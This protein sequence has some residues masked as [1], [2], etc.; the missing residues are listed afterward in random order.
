MHRFRLATIL[1]SLLF[2]AGAARSAPMT[3]TILSKISK[4]SFNLEH[5]GF[6]PVSGVMKISPGSFTFDEQDWSKSSVAVTLP[7]SKL[8]MG[9]GIW[10]EQIR[11]DKNWGA[12][13]QPLNI[14]FRSTRLERSDKSNGMLYGELTLAGITRPVALKVHVNKMGINKVSELQAIGLTAV[15]SLKRSEFGLGAYADLVGDDIAIQIQIEAAMGE[16]PDAEQEKALN[17]RT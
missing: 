2:C 3:Y 12:L 5:Q 14:S 8:D 7:I 16:D 1:A 10:N 11:K 15:G 6:I 13:F 4:V 17:T 9:D